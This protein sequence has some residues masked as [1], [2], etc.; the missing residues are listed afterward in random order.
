MEKPVLFPPLT[1]YAVG[2]SNCNDRFWQAKPCAGWG[3]YHTPSDFSCHLEYAVVL[4]F[5][6]EM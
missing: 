3:F 4:E 1:R 6:L 5:S 2:K